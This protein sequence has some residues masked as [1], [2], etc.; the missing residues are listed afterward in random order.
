MFRFGVSS[1]KTKFK[2]SKIWKNF[3]FLFFLFVFVG[4][5]TGYSQQTLK[6]YNNP[7]IVDK[8]VCDPHIHII[9]DKAYLFATHDHGVGYSFY[10]MYDW[11]MW[12]SKDLVH[13]E[14]EYTLKPEDMYVGP[15]K[16]A[17]A[18]DGVERNGNIYWYVSAHFKTAVVRS[19]N[20]PK[21]PFID[22]L[23]KPLADSYDPTV[24]IDDD[25]NKT[26]YLVVGGFPYKIAKL[27]E[28]MISLAE[29][30]KEIVHNS[31]WGDGDG[32]YLHKRNGIYY[33]NGHGTDY[34]TATNIYGPYTYRGKYIKNWVDHPTVFTWKNQSYTTFGVGDGDSFFR[35]TKIT[36]LHYKANGDI[37]G[38]QAVIDSYIGVGQY[39][40]SSP[41]QAEWYSAASSS[42]E[43]IENGEGFA[44]KNTGSESYLYFPRI[45]NVAKNPTFTVNYAAE[46]SLGSIEV[47][48]DSLKGELLGVLSLNSTGSLNTYSTSSTT[49]SSEA[50]L[51]NI[52]LVVKGDG[53]KISL[54]SYTLSSTGKVPMSPDLYPKLKGAQAADSIPYINA[55]QRIEAEKFAGAVGVKTENTSDNDG[56]SSLGYIE[57]YSNVVYKLDFGNE[58]RIVKF[59]AR[60]S[61]GMA[62]GGSIEVR[63]DSAKGATVGTIKVSN[64]GGWNSWTTLNTNLSPVLGKHLV[65]LVFIG[66]PQE[67]AFLFNLNWITFEAVI[68]VPIQNNPFSYTVRNLDNATVKNLQNGKYGT[69]EFG[70]LVPQTKI[71]IY[72]SLGF[73]IASL[74]TGDKSQI[75]WNRTDYQGKPVKPGIY[76]SKLSSGR[77]GKIFKITIP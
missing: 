48:G 2:F 20:G 33:L 29:P 4:L 36:Y 17:W 34:A 5:T 56:G 62:K 77:D 45:L 76:I 42:M 59:S 6:T 68:S 64:T 53:A 1:K 28:D 72:N 35:K 13:W 9:N 27:G 50:G 19:T 47:R 23:K 43:K 63:L 12:S 22:V 60:V 57:H 75:N 67:V 30:M 54:D 69:I 73:E 14:L 71:Q 15:T 3:N 41:I 58:S 11:W 55:Y 16:N 70:N 8:G 26:P 24:F 40:C 39:D 46:N 32:G 37:V 49:L 52:Y 18:V 10:T 61:S 66:E 44:V 74:E 7:I 51:K 25:A 65:Y 31:K 21:G 38:D